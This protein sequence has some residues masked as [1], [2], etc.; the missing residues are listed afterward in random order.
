MDQFHLCHPPRGLDHG[1]T[2][3]VLSVHAT[4]PPRNDGSVSIQQRPTYAGII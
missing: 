3:W 1:M 2:Q 4:T